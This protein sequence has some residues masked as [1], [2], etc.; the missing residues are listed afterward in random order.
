MYLVFEVFQER[1]FKEMLAMSYLV[2]QA[3]LVF[4]VSHTFD[5]FTLISCRFLALVETTSRSG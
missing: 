2:L 3:Y 5:F 1:Q 4:V